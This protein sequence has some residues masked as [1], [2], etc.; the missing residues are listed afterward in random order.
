MIRMY[1]ISGVLIMSTRVEGDDFIDISGLGT[2]VYLLK[3]DDDE[4]GVRIVIFD[5]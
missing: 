1:T 3:I 4:R 2:G 5:S